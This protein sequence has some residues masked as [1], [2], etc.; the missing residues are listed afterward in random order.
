[1]CA[2]AAT[3]HF[4]G[5]NILIAT[6]Y[7]N[8]KPYVCPSCG[9]SYGRTDV[10]LR[11]RR[12]CR[13]NQPG[14]ANPSA[15]SNTFSNDN[16]H[17]DGE[18]TEHSPQPD[19]LTAVAFASDTVQNSRNSNETRDVVDSTTLIS[20][21]T[22]RTDHQP[23]SRFERSQ[24]VDPRITDGFEANTT[25]PDVSEL[26]PTDVHTNNV[27][28]AISSNFS[29]AAPTPDGLMDFSAFQLD[30]ES[31]LEDVLLCQF[32]YNPSGLTI[33][34]T[35]TLAALPMPS[36]TDYADAIAQLDSTELSEGNGIKLS[37]NPTSILQITQDEL[38]LFHAKLTVTDAEEGLA[39]FKKPSLSRTLR[40]I[41]AY[42]RHFDPHA[43]FI[44]YASF[45]ISTAHP[46]L[47]L[48]M[49]AIGA[50]HLS[51]T[52]FA[53]SAYEAA[54]LLLAQHDKQYLRDD[55]ISFCLWQAQTTLLCAQF[56]VTSG[57]RD[58]F[59][60]A[61]KH[62]FA[63]HMMLGSTIEANRQ[64][65][66]SAAGDWM[67]WVF[68]E[69]CTRV[70]CWMFVVSATCFALDPVAMTIL[71]PIPEPIACPCDE[72]TWHAVSEIEWRAACRRDADVNTAEVDLWTL[73]KAIHH[74][75]LPEACGRM[76]A[77]TLLAL[78][79]GQLCTICTRERLRLDIYDS[80]EFSYIQRSEKALMT[81]ERLWRKHPR[82]EQSLTRLD[83]PLLNDCLSLHCSAY[84]HLYFGEELVTL[85]RI[86]E[87]P[88][89]GICL[90]GYKNNSQALKA[91]KYAASSWLVR[92]KI[93]VK[94]LSR[95]K[96]LEL[97]PQALSAAYESALILAWWLHLNGDTLFNGIY[98]TYDSNEDRGVAVAVK[99]IFGDILY[100]LDEQDTLC[101][102]S[103]PVQL[104]PID[105][106]ACLCR[107][108]VW[109]YSSMIESR[110]RGFGAHLQKC[111][112]V[113]E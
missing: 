27:S 63:T 67:T 48:I 76:S 69:T 94:Y 19:D 57:R 30:D 68:L 8:K 109:G 81:W 22:Y 86:A 100:E 89:C 84:Y 88:E 66:A 70:V 101:S 42:F 58:L 49:L 113:G 35:P 80:T 106:Y 44:H 77:F 31:F 104:D 108:G 51:E 10:L 39:N 74:G 20:G 26:V 59:S 5:L 41:I 40:C 33:P 29:V 87:N 75:Q 54:C 47:V 55:D 107:D 32:S 17:D 36:I 53:G 45:N 98:E 50:L 16:S 79:S 61:Q 28:E 112:R 2:R 38:E 56:G 105:F 6:Y 92:A 82:A 23:Q 1:M 111:R 73:A 72:S 90:P 15:P 99:R 46:A 7:D 85:K 91:I 25:G 18:Y 83:D 110:L 37:P 24:I 14:K 13:N 12:T 3:G 52:K 64:L 96:G 103:G 95:S 71:P 11:H 93:G 60:R 34:S 4:Y 65:R 21:S 97:G 43:P 62:L 9:S 78:V 102:R